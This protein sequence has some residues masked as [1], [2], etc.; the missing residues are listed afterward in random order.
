VAVKWGW[1]CE[2]LERERGFEPPAACLE[3]RF[4]TNLSYCRSMV[5]FCAEPYRRP[6]LPYGARGDRQMFYKGMVGSRRQV[7]AG[8]GHPERHC[9][10]KN[11]YL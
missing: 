2:G 3:G 7:P 6:L 1:F 8:T 11:L 4:S 5:P 10:R 9:C